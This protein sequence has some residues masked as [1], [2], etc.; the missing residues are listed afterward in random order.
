L[1][2]TAERS[3]KLTGVISANFSQ[4][5]I[6]N[7]LGSTLRLQITIAYKEDENKKL[8]LRKKYKFRVL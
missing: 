4:S 6:S 1:L 3:D 7:I 2:Y 8:K 5:T